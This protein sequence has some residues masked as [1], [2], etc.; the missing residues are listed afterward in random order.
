MVTPAVER[1]AVAHLQTAFGMSER[2]ACKI[3]GCFRMTMR[4][5]TRRTDDVVLRE[6]M[7]AIAHMSGDGSAIDGYTSCCAAKGMWSITS[8]CSASTGKRSCRYV[9]EVAGNGQWA[10]GGRC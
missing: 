10:Q 4:Y 8:A 6:R 9:D 2:R 5:Q 7:K 3:L 1:D